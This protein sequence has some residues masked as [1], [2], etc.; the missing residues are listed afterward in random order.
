MKLTKSCNLRIFTIFS[1]LLIFSIIQKTLSKKSKRI[2]N[3]PNGDSAIKKL[4]SQIAS[5][6][7]QLKIE[8]LKNTELTKKLKSREIIKL[9]FLFLGCA[10]NNGI[11]EFQSFLETKSTTKTD[12]LFKVMSMGFP[13]ANKASYTGLD[14][15]I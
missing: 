11:E 7:E 6:K 9:L 2:R 3:K 10:M 1:I 14:S 8:T 4:E 5:L 13:A 15:K 12:P